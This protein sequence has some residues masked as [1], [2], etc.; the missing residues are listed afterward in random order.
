MKTIYVT[1]PEAVDPDN[2]V[3]QL[4]NYLLTDIPC[5][6]KVIETAPYVKLALEFDETTVDEKKVLAE[7]AINEYVIST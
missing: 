1:D 2:F 7:L 4:S 3:W 6:I 5:E